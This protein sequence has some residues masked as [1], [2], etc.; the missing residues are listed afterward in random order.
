MIEDFYALQPYSLSQPEKEQMLLNEL[1][2]LIG[3][4]Y[5]NCLPYRNM[6]EGLGVDIAGINSVAEVPFFPVRMFKELDLLS[7]PREKVFKTTT[8]SGTTGQKVS[9]VYADMETAMIQQK[10]L[11][12]IFGDFLGKKRLPMLVIDSAETVRNRQLFSAR[13]AAIIGL[14]MIASKQIFA[15]D[16]DM[17]LQRDMVCDFLREHA[18]QKFLLFGFTFMAWQHFYKELLKIEERFDLS[19]AFLMTSG[20]W[21]KLQSEAVSKEEFKARF[22]EVCGLR[23][24]L[25]HYGMAEQIGAIHAECECGHLH[26]SVYSDIIPRRYKDFSPCKVG[27]PGILQMVS[28]LPH[29]YPGHSLISEDKGVLLGID[30]CPCGRKGKYF[31]VLGRIKQ[32]EIRGCSDTY[33]AKF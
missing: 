20:G 3:H 29:S 25:D 27:E 6:L 4:H 19:E 32:A 21:K 14:Q 1:K 26:A 28:V 9:R 5:E 24:F 18:G 10:V 12:K 17:N 33:A 31:Q 8:S 7:I 13:G 22:E 11:I 15:L 30:D 2:V 23:H 16:K